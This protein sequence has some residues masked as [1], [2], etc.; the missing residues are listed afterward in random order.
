M[1]GAVRTPSDSIVGEGIAAGLAHEMLK[2]GAAGPVLFFC[3]ETRREELP[4]RLRK[5]GIDV[6]EVV[7]YRS[8]LASESEAR[9]AVMLGSVVVVASPSVGGLLVRACPPDTRPDLIAVGPT[10]A[11]SLNAS[12]WPPAAVAMAPTANA[13]ATAVGEVLA[14]RHV[15]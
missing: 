2:A 1:L 10:T 4:D 14:M 3:G 6:D 15:S 8:V 7:C 11:S 13:V 12:G 5:R 9:A